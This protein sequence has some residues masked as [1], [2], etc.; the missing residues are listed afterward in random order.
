ML[1]KDVTALLKENP[2]CYV[3]I[4]HVRVKNNNELIINLG[5][6]RIPI[7]IGDVLNFTTLPELT[8]GMST[9][10]RKQTLVL[11]NNPKDYTDSF[12]AKYVTQRTCPRTTSVYSFSSGSL[13]FEV[14]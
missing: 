7:P 6:T 5:G 10:N 8:D 9:P 3:I 11:K 14:I 13:D 12:G 1:S 4:A 2:N